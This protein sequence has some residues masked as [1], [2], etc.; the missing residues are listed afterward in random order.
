MG[1]RHAVG[2]RCEQAIPRSEREQAGLR[3]EEKEEK[4]GNTRTPALTNLWT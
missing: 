2:G 3:A 1:S 4:R